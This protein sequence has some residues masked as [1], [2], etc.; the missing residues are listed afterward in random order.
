MKNNF[1]AK[2]NGGTSVP[3]PD[4]ACRSR[5]VWGVI[6]LAGLFACG[7]F[8][9]TSLMGRSGNV[10]MRSD[11]KRIALSESQCNVIAINISNMAASSN[12]SPDKVAM[13]RELN[14]IY[15]KNCKGRIVAAPKPA[16]VNSYDTDAEPIATC[17]LI[18]QMLSDAI[19]P[20]DNLNPIAHEENITLYTRLMNVGCAENR[21]KY[22]ALIER[23]RT[24]LNAL[25]TQDSV[26]ADSERTCTKIENEVR[27][28]L[29]EGCIG[30]NAHVGNAQV[31]ANLSE[32]G[33]PENSDK[34]VALAKQELEL[35]R[36]VTDDHFSSSDAS[37]VI[38]TYVRLGMM[39]AAQ[40]ML[41]RAKKYGAIRD[42]FELADF[43]N[44]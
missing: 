40:D 4:C 22:T 32:R 37:S 30:I 16:V 19:Y 3:R 33:C 23:E 39:S 1:N 15:S 44:E 9:G 28:Q 25:K 31:Y 18:E 20:E 6:A 27:E 13:L 26:R 10:G 7:W 24:I 38:E 43:I 2:T 21:E 29:C 41:N 34:Y 11:I 35:A 8:V 12:S 17:E 42:D 36:A 14:D 5:K